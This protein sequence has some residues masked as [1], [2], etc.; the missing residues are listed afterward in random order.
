[1]VVLIAADSFVGELDTT[2]RNV[3]CEGGECASLD[4]G[5]LEWQALANTS[6]VLAPNAAEFTS[7]AASHALGSSTDVV[8]R[9]IIG[10]R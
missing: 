10:I 9:P 5:D 6:S 8:L 4:L 2:S 1:V 7:E 3:Q